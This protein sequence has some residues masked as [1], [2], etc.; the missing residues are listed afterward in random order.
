LRLF[1]KVLS[2]FSNVLRLFSKVATFFK[3]KTLEK[4]PGK[5]PGQVE[6]R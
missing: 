4:N 6:G 3:N 5:R 2:L 1:S